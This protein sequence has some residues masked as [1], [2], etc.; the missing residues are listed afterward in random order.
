MH[1]FLDFL[2]RRETTVWSR[3]GLTGVVVGLISLL[4]LFVPLNTAPFLLYM[5]VIFIFGVAFGRGP[6]LLGLAISAGCATYFFWSTPPVGELSL[7]QALAVAQYL[8]IGA[9]MVLVCD[10]LRELMR[11][12]EA[13]A[14]AA[15]AAQAE[16]EAAKDAAEAANRA[17]SAFLANMSHEL[18]TPLSA[19]I[20]Y[21]EMLQEELAE[22]DRRDMLPDLG[23]IE[24]NARHLLGLI[25]DVLDLSKIEA[26]RM[27]VFAEEVD[28]ARLAAEAAEA[29]G[30]LVAAKRNRLTLEVAPGIGTM[31]TDAV[32]LRQCLLNLLGNAA[33]FTEDGTVALRVARE[34]TDALAFSVSDTG[35]GMSEEQM[36]RLFRRFAQAD[37][38]TTRRF[39][40]TGL[41]LALTRAFAHLLGG[42]VAVEST[43]GRGS[44]FT[45]RLP[46]ELPGPSVLE[47]VPVPAA[48]V[49]IPLDA[50]LSP[51]QT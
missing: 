13:A 43:P 50:A 35:I 37:E 45:L 40:G 3:Y 2:S 30:A 51:A 36:A 18:R 10:A 39:G 24:S 16:A 15:R 41:G 47:P 17:K 9:G 49:A 27:D 1:A 6:G 25:N 8:V 46:A 28:V 12:N 23:R 26:N 22:G 32:K 4:R 7:D 48:A 31:R 29:V 38:S 44:C 33:K 5:P 21:S 20:G 34:G 19:V 42:D 11:Q 14:A